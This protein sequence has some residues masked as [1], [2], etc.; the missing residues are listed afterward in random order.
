MKLTVIGG[1]YVGL[2]TGAC[3][4]EVG[5]NV[6]C[7][8]ID[9][10]KIEN[11]NKGIIPIYEPDLEGMVKNNLEK[12]RLRFT[13]DIQEAV[14]FAKLQMIAVGTPPM[15]SGEADLRFVKQVAQSIGKY[16]TEDKIVVNKS[17]VPVGTG[18][19][20]KE[21][22]VGELTKRKANYKVSVASNPEFLKEGAAI[23]DFMRPDRIIVGT[24]DEDTEKV[25]T[26]LYDPFQKNHDRIIFMD[27]RSSELTKYA[28]NA[29]LATRISFMNELSRLSELV[30]SDIEYV[31][32]GIGADPRIGN[33]F[34]YP[35]IGYGGSCFPKDVSALIHMG[36]SRDLDLG[37][38]TA[39]NQANENQKKYFVDK[40]LRRFNNSIDG[41]T[42]AVWGLAF[43]PNTDD[44]RFA[45]S[46]EI[47]KALSQRGAKIQAYDPIATS[48]AKIAL[49]ETKN[50]TFMSDS[51]EALRGA[52]ALVVNTEWRE[53]KSLNFE[54]L[55]ERM[56]E[57]IIFD[58]RNIYKPE[59]VKAAGFEYFGIG[60]KV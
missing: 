35:G 41:R 52:S 51:Q 50:V 5:H 22:I 40:I 15:E 57:K 14:K 42:F 29:M 26:A 3:L 54:N 12:G 10:E 24:E 60:R 28:A 9:S 27:V 49:A 2:V 38:L 19:L 37:V 55:N 6:L 7:L 33:L 43:K 47:I 45:P 23:D 16:M 39:V 59:E 30:G 36:K 13:T 56:A 11:L 48:E 31:R 34:L 32:K 17:T 8:D 44:I 53:F 21:V 58:G 20:V 1:G 18:D 46:I 25:M 4:A